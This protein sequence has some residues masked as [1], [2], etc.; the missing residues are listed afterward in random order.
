MSMAHSLE[1]RAPFLDYRVIAFAATLPSRWKISRGD[2]KIL[3]WNTFSRLLPQTVLN[4]PKQGFTVPLAAWF[5]GE[6]K[7]FAENNLLQQSGMDGYF[8]LEGVA[9]LWQEHQSGRADHGTL[10]WSLLMLSLWHTEYL[11]GNRV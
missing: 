6:L 9:R 10:L 2:K 11:G 5:R 8:S 7:G 3:L 4:R 1:V